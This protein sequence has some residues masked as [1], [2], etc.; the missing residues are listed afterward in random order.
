MAEKWT[1]PSISP[2]N[3]A[4]ENTSLYARQG[5]RRG[6]EG[7]GKEKTHMRR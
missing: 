3:L 4:V 2:H 7:R 1:T 6:W 5:K